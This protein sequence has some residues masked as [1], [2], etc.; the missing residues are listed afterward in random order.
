VRTDAEACAKH[1]ADSED[2]QEGIRAQ[3]EKR[4]PL[5]HGR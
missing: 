3:R 5:F 2:L 1:C 4:A